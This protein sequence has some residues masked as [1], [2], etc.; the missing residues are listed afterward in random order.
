MSKGAHTNPAITWKNGVV[1]LVM[2]LGFI[3]PLNI[4]MWLWGAGAYC[5]AIPMFAIMENINDK[6][7][8]PNP[9]GGADLIWGTGVCTIYLK[10]YDEQYDEVESSGNHFGIKVVMH[11]FIHCLQ[12]GLVSGDADPAVRYDTIDVIVENKCGIPDVYASKTV[13]AFAALPA[14]FRL[15]KKVVVFY[16]CGNGYEYTQAEIEDKVYGA[17]CPG[18]SPNQGPWEDLNGFGEGDAEYYSMNTIMPAVVQ[19]WT[20]PYN[21]PAEW[22]QKNTEC[23]QRCGLPG[24]DKF[25]IGDLSEKHVEDQ[26]IPALRDG[27]YDDCRNNCTG[28]LVIKFL[29]E[30]RPATTVAEIL[31]V[32]KG[33]GSVGFGASW[34]T[35]IGESW[36]DFSKALERSSSYTNDASSDGSP[37]QAKGDE[38]IPEFTPAKIG[39]LTAALVFVSFCCFVKLVLLV[40]NVVTAHRANAEPSSAV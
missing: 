39:G 35:S 34:E 29:L 13:A 18:M 38:Y 8:K 22:T 28:E 31:D 32:W 40:R 19:P 4:A 27:G 11:E 33:A 26:M 25:R 12:H 16:A 6:M 36:Q 3:G 15:I 20:T 7:S 1:A 14:E 17:G 24:N 9:D 37:G 30:R 2:L 21:G 10:P 5:P 23:L